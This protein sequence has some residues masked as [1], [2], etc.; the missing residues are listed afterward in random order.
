MSRA[1]ILQHVPHEGPGRITPVFRDF[2]IP[3]EVRKLFAGDEVPTDLDEV[4]VLVVMGGPMGVSDVGSEK[5]PF[6]AKE[7]ELLKRCVGLDRPVLGICL[8]AQLLAH[9]G[10]ARVYPNVK[11]APPAGPGQ[12]PKPVEP[13]EPLPEI[14]W[15]PVT[16]PFPGGTEPLVMGL[17]DS[18]MMFHWHFDTFDLPKLPPPANPAPPP[19][20][21]PPTGNALM[22][23]SR[24]CRNQAYRFKNRLFGF[25]YHFEMNE[26]GIEAMLEHAKEDWQKVLGPDGA[27]KIREDTKKLYPKYARQGDRI[28]KNFVQFLKAY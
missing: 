5:Y 22:S 3:T 10:G 1:I 21:P 27:T 9:A 23:S 4:R 28:L 20:P 17:H 24:L 15:L 19:A 14:G 7:V 6:L 18:S 8:G 26:D 2:G 12:P 16:F 25:Q 13:A 11:M